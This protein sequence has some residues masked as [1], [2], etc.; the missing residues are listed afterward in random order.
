MKRVPCPKCQHLIV[1][2]E[3]RYTAGQTLV[4]VCEECKKQFSIR[5]G[6]GKL[7]AKHGD[8]QWDEIEKEYITKG[9]GC[10]IVIENIFAYKQI[11]PL[12]LGEN[13]IGRKDLGT[14][15]TTPIETSDRSMDRKHCY[16]QVEC[17]AKGKRSYTLRDFPSIT[18][19]FLQNSILGDRDRVLLN[20]GDVITLGA[21]S[22]IFRAATE[23]D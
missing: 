1:F 19:T 23:S 18:G 9:N 5:L 17:N 21:T 4:F 8:E 7:R 6:T 3:T 15:I 20:D 14:N 13:L 12:R 16:I 10:L 2:D 22:L 11:L